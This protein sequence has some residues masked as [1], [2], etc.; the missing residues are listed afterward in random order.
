[1]YCFTVKD[2][3]R[4]EPDWLNSL[5]RQTVELTTTMIM[6]SIDN[7][8]LKFLDL[9]LMAIS[10]DRN[11]TNFT[12][13]KKMADTSKDGLLLGGGIRHITATS[14]FTRGSKV[15]FACVRNI[16]LTR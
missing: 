3:L 5:F 7:R 10:T 16:V 6:Y 14:Q 9:V 8:I 13:R 15:V 2:S 4:R 11:V 12:E 1:M